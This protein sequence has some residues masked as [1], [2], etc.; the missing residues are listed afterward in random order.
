[1]NSWSTHKATAAE[2]LGIVIVLA[3]FLPIV[4]F[5]LGSLVPS[6]EASAMLGF[7]PDIPWL[8]VRKVR[9]APHAAVVFALAGLIVMLLGAAIV[10]RQRPVFEAMRARRQ[11]A[12]RRVRQYEP[13][14]RIEPTLN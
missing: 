1:M 12:L 11:D 4:V 2:V 10:R 5:A 14:D 9:W 7:F 3:G 8:D 6:A 13:A